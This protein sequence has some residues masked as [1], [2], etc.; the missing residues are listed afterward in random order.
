[1]RDFLVFLPLLEEHAHLHERVLATAR[2]F[3][4]T[5]SSAERLDIGTFERSAKPNRPSEHL[6]LVI[7]RSPAEKSFEMDVSRARALESVLRSTLG[8]AGVAP[9]DVRVFVNSDAGRKSEASSA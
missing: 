2:S 3:F 9:I 7:I 6:P 1:M 5:I 8:A 4:E